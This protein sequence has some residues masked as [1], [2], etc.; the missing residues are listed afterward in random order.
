MIASPGNCQSQLMIIFFD[1]SSR[2]VILLSLLKIKQNMFFLW[3]HS[4]LKLLVHF[5]FVPR[6]W[7]VSSA[8]RSISLPNAWYLCHFVLCVCRY[9]K[10]MNCLICLVSCL[11]CEFNLCNFF[12]SIF[13]LFEKKSYWFSVVS[14]PWTNSEIFFL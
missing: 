7:W 13:V 6:S 14:I 2:S 5:Q 3:F 12:P 9:N 10:P 4:I 1:D 8:L 11:A